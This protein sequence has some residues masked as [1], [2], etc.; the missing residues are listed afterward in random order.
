MATKKTATVKTEKE[1]DKKA[2]IAELLKQLEAANLQTEKR[3]LRRSLRALGHKG[4]L[5][6]AK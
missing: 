2:K 5:G 1:D 3:T 6:K 4:G